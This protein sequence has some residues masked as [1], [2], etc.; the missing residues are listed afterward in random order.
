MKE[1]KKNVMV[2]FVVSLFF[3]ACIALPASTLFAERQSKSEDETCDHCQKPIS[4]VAKDSEWGAKG[5]PECAPKPLENEGKVTGKEDFNLTQKSINVLLKKEKIPGFDWGFDERFRQ[6]YVK[7]AR[8]LNKHDKLNQN[9]FRFRSRLWFQLTPWD[10]LEGYVR[11]TNEC[12]AWTQGRTADTLEDMNEVFFDNIYFG[13]KRP[14]GLPFSVRMGRQDIVYG[15]GF[16]FIEGTPLDGSRSQYFDAIKSTLHLDPIKTDID[17]LIIDLNRE[18]RK[19]FRF[20]NSNQALNEDEVRAYGYYITNTYFKD[21]KLEHY[22]LYR[23]ANGQTDATTQ[24]LNTV[25]G[26]ISGTVFDNLK[27]ASEMAV[28]WGDQGAVHRDRN[29][30]GLGTYVEGTYNFPVKFKP[31][32]GTGYKYLSGDDPRTA[33]IESFDPLFGRWPTDNY[34]LYYLFAREGRLGLWTNMHKYHIGGG[35]CPFDWWSVSLYY[36]RF[37]SDKN[38]FQGGTPGFSSGNIRGNLL[39]LVNKFEFSKNFSGQVWIEVFDPG[40]YFVD[41]ADSALFFQWQFVVKY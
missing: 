16:L 21:L 19:F 29:R 10:W 24:K 33:K 8:R 6:E 35:F 27:Y 7:N 18:D 22:Y 31:S 36:Q 38:T 4:E 25:G 14:G 37:W 40:N 15:Q 41:T 17:A 3:L 5:G 1:N 12:R 13:L 34:I 39:Q 26:R 2:C 32:I 9:Y 23:D 30:D 11:L 28:Q 20:N